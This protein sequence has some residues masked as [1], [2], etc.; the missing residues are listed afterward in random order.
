MMGF[1]A[2]TE[3]FFRTV[4]LSKSDSSRVVG[5]GQS[6]VSSGIRSG[7]PSHQVLVNSVSLANKSHVDARVLISS[8]NKDDQC[9]QLFQCDLL[10]CMSVISANGH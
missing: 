8:Q 5:E 6:E 2:L 1:S 3:R 7:G 4:T 9:Q 10:C